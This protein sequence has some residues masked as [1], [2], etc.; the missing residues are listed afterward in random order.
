MGIGGTEG[1]DRRIGSRLSGPKIDL[2]AAGAGRLCSQRKLIGPRF[3]VEEDVDE[4][5]DAARG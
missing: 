3:V 1:C 2:S 5:R 4:Q